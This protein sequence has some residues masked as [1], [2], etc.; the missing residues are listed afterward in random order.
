MASDE[1]RANL[2]IAATALNA[3]LGS[4]LPALILMTDDR[5]L[6]DPAAAAR[7][8]PAGSAVIA[9]H[10]RDGPRRELAKALSPIVRA[11]GLLLLIANDPA[12][13]GDI[14]ADGL[15]LSEARASEASPWRKSHPRWLVTAAAHSEAAVA[16][17]A[18]AGADA[19]LLS[20]VFGTASH[21]DRPAIGVDRF[22]SMARAAPIPVYAL[23]GVTAENARLLT[24]PNVAGIAAIGALIPS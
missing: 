17:A 15:H 10:M 11:R 18:E 12:L 9:R 21:P 3:R 7:A 20:P 2:A 8:L 5:R 1:E 24:G 6:P 4:R 22:L 14:G 23:G 16:I 19:A 13:A